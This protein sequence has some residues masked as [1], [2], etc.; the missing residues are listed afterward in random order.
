[1]LA[2]KGKFDGKQVI[3]PETP[4]LPECRVIVVFESDGDFAPDRSAWMRAQ[5]ETLA[6]IWENEEDAIYDTV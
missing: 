4:A 1:M 5:Q 2:M 3:L 6:S